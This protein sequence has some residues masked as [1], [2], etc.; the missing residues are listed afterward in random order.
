MPRLGMPAA[1]AASWLCLASTASAQ[2]PFNVAVPLTTLASALAT[3]YG[4]DGLIVESLIALP[5]GETHSAHFNGDAI[6]FSK[7]FTTALTGKLVSTPLPSLA[8]GFTYEFDPTLG[9]FTRTTESFGPI[10]AER[11]ETIGAG[12]TAWG[13]TYQ[14]FTFDTIEGLDL[15]QI[16]TV[17]T[18]DG[19][20]LRG[21][22]D[23]VVTAV[24]AIDVSVGQFTAFA[25]Y[26]ATDGFDVSVAVPFVTTDLTVVSD[27]R[28]HRVGT[29]DPQV[30]FFRSV[31]GTLGD[32]RVFTA[33]GRASGVGD[34]TI[35]LKSTLAR[36]GPQ[37]FAVGM[38]LRLPTGDEQN[39]LGA[40]A[41]GVKGFFVWSRASRAFSPH[42]NAGYLWNGSSTLAGNPA[43]G[44]SE[45]LAD[46]VAYTA[47]ADFGLNP[48]LTFALDLLGQVAIGT[49]RLVQRDFEHLNGVDVFPDITFANSTFN[50]LSMAL[51]LKVGLTDEVL[52]DFNLVFRLDDN[53][54]RDKVTPLVG[55]EYAR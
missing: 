53:G 48:R 38:D 34:V 51:G 19:F 50:E 52:V 7:K 28:I 32:R 20:E 5:S 30:H 27:V 46:L 49:P 9:V 10:L 14:R 25:T 16:P 44:E 6:P 45:D 40:G 15:R 37:G 41:P 24:N 47:G 21:G 36:R 18:H 3:L 33:F 54:L 39:L 4:P 29:T 17:F 23:D 31:D 35:R 26:G 1:A 13:V 8:S 11:A 12:R 42:V 2:A 55:L 43:T 22:R